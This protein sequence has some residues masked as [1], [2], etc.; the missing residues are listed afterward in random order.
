VYPYSLSVLS[1]GVSGSLGTRFLGITFALIILL[2]RRTRRA[3]FAASATIRHSRRGIKTQFLSFAGTAGGRLCNS[4]SRSTMSMDSDHSSDY[5]LVGGIAKQAGHN[6]PGQS[7]LNKRLGPA[8]GRTRLNQNS[9]SNTI[10]NLRRL[11]VPLARK[12]KQPCPRPYA[13]F[14]SIPF[15]PG[16]WPRFQYFTC[17]RSTLGW[18]STKKFPL[19]SSECSPPR[20]PASS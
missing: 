5:S 7:W 11:P 8:G 3:I 16:F 17:T 10:G 15:I 4:A 18:L 20:Q 2:L 13:R 19:P 12:S 6:L 1:Y 9:T 14:Y